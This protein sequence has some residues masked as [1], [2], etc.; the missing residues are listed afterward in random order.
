MQAVLRQYR[1]LWF[2]LRLNCDKALF[3]AMISAALVL[4]GWIMSVLTQGP[5]VIH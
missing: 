4:G 1:G 5:F 3:V 2:L